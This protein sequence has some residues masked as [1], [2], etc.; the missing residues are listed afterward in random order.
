M[1]KILAQLLQMYK[2]N[3]LNDSE[4]ITIAGKDII[5]FPKSRYN[6]PLVVIMG[7]IEKRY[8]FCDNTMYE[9]KYPF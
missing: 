6:N 8:I 9:V 3:K 1:K 4:V 5:Y 2:N 7:K